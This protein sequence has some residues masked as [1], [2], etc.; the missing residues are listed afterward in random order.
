M[1]WVIKECPQCKTKMVLVIAN[2]HF[3]PKL[4]FNVHCN[5]CQKITKYGMEKFSADAKSF[6][7]KDLAELLEALLK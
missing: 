4:R 6:E 1:E 3:R 5:N 2:M 7:P